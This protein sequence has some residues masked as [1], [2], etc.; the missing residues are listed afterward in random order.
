M[1]RSG[2]AVLPQFFAEYMAFGIY[3]I[4]NEVEDRTSDLLSTKKERVISQFCTEWGKKESKGELEKHKTH[5]LGT[6]KSWELNNV[7]DKFSMEANQECQVLWEWAW[8][9]LKEQT[10]F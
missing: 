9:Y 2:C 1:S 8:Q 4:Q 10:V 5:R 6:Q 7:W 3:Y